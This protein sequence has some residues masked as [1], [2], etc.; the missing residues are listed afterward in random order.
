MIG[1][2]GTYKGSQ[3][4]MGAYVFRIVYEEFGQQLM[5]SKVV[6]GTVTLIR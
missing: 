2:D 1:W 5:E 3:C 6:E 4:M